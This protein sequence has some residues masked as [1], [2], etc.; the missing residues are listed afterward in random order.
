MQ[1]DTEK[2]ALLAFVLTMIVLLVWAKF[3]A[4]RTPPKKAEPKKVA[5]KVEKK[6]PAPKVSAGGPLPYPSPSSANK[7]RQCG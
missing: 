3:F 2:R 7:A 4:P 5:E 6:K 1:L